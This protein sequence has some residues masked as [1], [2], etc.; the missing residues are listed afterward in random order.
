[1]RRGRDGVPAPRICTWVKA[2]DLCED[3]VSENFPWYP[4]LWV[5][6]PDLE[7]RNPKM[8]HLVMYRYEDGLVQDHLFWHNS[9]LWYVRYRGHR[10]VAEAAFQSGMWIKDLVKEVD[11]LADQGEVRGDVP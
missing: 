8:V 11:F 9:P 10:L 1:M 2:D 3:R 7:D 4:V 6:H 5:T